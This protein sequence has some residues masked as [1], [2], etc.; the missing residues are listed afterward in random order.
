MGLGACVYMRVHVRVCVYRY[1]CEF[2]CVCVCECV[3]VCVFTFLLP[4]QLVICLYGMISI[5]K[6][7]CA[8]ACVCVFASMF[9]NIR[10]H[11]LGGNVKCFLPH[12]CIVCLHVSVFYPTMIFCWDIM[13][14]HEIVIK[15][16]TFTPMG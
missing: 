3:C 6:Q 15:R 2:V 7:V 14:G 4:V 8:C 5:T 9:A 13:L 1:M 12:K 10:P 16:Y 11:Q